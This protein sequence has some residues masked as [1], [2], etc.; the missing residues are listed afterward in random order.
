MNRNSFKAVFAVCLVLGLASLTFGQQRFKVWAECNRG[1][2]RPSYPKTMHFEYGDGFQIA[3]STDY[4]QD[5]VFITKDSFQTTTEFK[6][7]ENSRKYFVNKSTDVRVN[8][9]LNAILLKVYQIGEYC[10]SHNVKGS[11]SE[12]GRFKVLADLRR[13]LGLKAPISPRGTKEANGEVGLPTKVQS[14]LN[15]NYVGWKLTA[16]ANGCFDRFKH[17]I[18]IGDFDG[19]RRDDYAVKFIHNQKGYIIAFLDRG[20]SYEHH[21]LVNTSARDVLNKGLSM[22][23]KGERIENR[24]GTA[25]RL[26]NDALNIGTC[27]SHGC[28]YIYRNGSFNCG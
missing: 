10:E 6:F 22:E 11:F 13:H 16:I 28:L 19:N 20:A 18:I 25:Y 26:L 14:F 8:P 27:E 4:P 9:T 2:D 17:D 24:D 12:T 3:T 21:L 23:R 15:K 7:E 1:C 5:G